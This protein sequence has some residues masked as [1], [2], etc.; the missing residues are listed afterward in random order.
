MTT[1]TES[2]YQVFECGGC[3]QY[4]PKGFDGDCRD[5]ANRLTDDVLDERYGPYGWAIVDERDQTGDC[6]A[7]GEN[8]GEKHLIY[9][10]EESEALCPACALS[11]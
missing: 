2:Q 1:E 10:I 4:H 7:C 3:C 9:D 6:T 8:V 11:T 5:D